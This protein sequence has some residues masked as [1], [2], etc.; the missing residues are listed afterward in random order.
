MNK[1]EALKL[2]DIFR[3]EEGAD[4]WYNAGVKVD[5]LLGKLC[6]YT[7]IDIKNNFTS[8]V[9]DFTLGDVIAIN[10]DSS[11]LALLSDKK[12]GELETAIQGLYVVR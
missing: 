2:G 6:G 12:I 9:N 10:S 8:I 3:Y 1:V 5:G 11:L 4:G 7:L